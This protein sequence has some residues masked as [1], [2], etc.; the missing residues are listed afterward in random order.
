M[1]KI[2]PD[3]PTFPTTAMDGGTY[4]E[5]LPIRL[6]IAGQALTGILANSAWNLQALERL[7]HSGESA[8]GLAS[9]LALEYADALLEA[10]NTQ[11]V[12]TP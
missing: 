4:N 10:H 9:S 6:W 12:R 7:G 1:T 5:G 8:F 11:P 2:Q 3:G